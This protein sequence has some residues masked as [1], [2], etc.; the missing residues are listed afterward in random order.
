[1]VGQALYVIV[2]PSMFPLEKLR[3]KKKSM[4]SRIH[5]RSAVQVAGGACL[6]RSF[7]VL[8]FFPPSAALVFSLTCALVLGPSHFWKR[9]TALP[10]VHTGC[11]GRR[12]HQGS[13]R[14]RHRLG[15]GLISVLVQPGDRSPFVCLCLLSFDLFRWGSEVRSSCFVSQYLSPCVPRE[16]LLSRSI[17]HE[18]QSGHPWDRG[19]PRLR[20]RY[21]RGITCCTAFE[22]S[23][24][25]RSGLISLTSS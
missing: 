5:R 24:L 18:N 4:F 11:G 13:Q 21:V 17:L 2:F 8:F 9:D 12:L 1:M 15:K 6:L 19:S 16:A 22:H 3:V 7:S 14:W 20:T 23:S 25:P 10:R